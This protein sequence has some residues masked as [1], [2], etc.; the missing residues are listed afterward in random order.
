MASSPYRRYG[1]LRFCAFPA[2]TFDIGSYDICEGQTK[3]SILH[4]FGVICHVLL[5]ITRYFRDD[6]RAQPRYSLLFQVVTI[7]RKLTVI[8][9]R[10][11]SLV[12]NHTN[13]W[14]VPSIR[15]A[16]N[17][18][19]VRRTL[20]FEINSEPYINM[21][22]APNSERSILDISIYLLLVL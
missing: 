12:K 19:L 3:S 1:L 17:N 9:K 18:I 20:A 14:G 7:T 13:L 16:N 15:C 8:G 2:H 21:K 22:F 5:H 11:A 10:Y 4:Y 6:L